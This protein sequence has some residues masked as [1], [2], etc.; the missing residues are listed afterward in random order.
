[1]SSDIQQ[2]IRS[3]M[4]REGVDKRTAELMLEVESGGDIDADDDTRTSAADTEHFWEIVRK[5]T[6]QP[7]SRTTTA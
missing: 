6:S 2:K 3:H 1:M 7:S 5:R 4:E